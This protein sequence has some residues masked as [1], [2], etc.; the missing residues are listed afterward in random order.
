MIKNVTPTQ[1]AENNQLN[2]PKKKTIDFLLQLS[3]SLEV[4]TTKA[5]QVEYLKN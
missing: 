3:K 1:Q 4:K 2:G 5:L